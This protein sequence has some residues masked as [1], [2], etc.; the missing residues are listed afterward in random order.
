[1]AR[2]KKDHMAIIEGATS[3]G[4]LHF[5]LFQSEKKHGIKKYRIGPAISKKIFA[6]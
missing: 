6:P 5:G 1:M 2:R 4:D 3:C